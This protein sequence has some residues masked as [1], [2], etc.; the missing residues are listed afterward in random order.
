MHA[1]SDTSSLGNK[2]ADIASEYPHCIQVKSV[3]P[4][5]VDLATVKLSFLSEILSL[6]K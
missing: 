6:Q 3:L 2:C 4:V 5:L 1:S